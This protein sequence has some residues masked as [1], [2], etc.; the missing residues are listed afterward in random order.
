MTSQALK[1]IEDE[2]ARQQLVEG[3]TP[4]HDDTH[5]NG[6]MALA[7]SVYSEVASDVSTHKYGR[8]LAAAGQ[9][10]FDWPW[11]PSWFKP[12]DPRRDLVKA[13]A[14]IVAEIERL[15]RAEGAAVTAPV[16][17]VDRDK[18]IELLEALHGLDV[19]GVS[20][21]ADEDGAGAGPAI[22]DFSLQTDRPDLWIPLDRILFRLKAGDVVL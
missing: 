9:A 13:G 19:M 22:N 20:E 14:L 2:R 15:D 5:V 16:Q 7:A 3:W 10:P 11:D 12:T 8:S 6:E 18:L 21:S 1:D 4:E 17:T